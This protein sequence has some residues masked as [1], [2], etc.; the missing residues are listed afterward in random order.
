MTSQDGKSGDYSA[1]QRLDS[2]ICAV[3]GAGQG[4]GRE[5]AIALRSAGASVVCLDIDLA[6]ALSVAEEVGGSAFAMDA[7]KPEIVEAVV[8]DIVAGHG[9]LDAVIDIVGASFGAALL[10]IDEALIRRNF[11]LNLFQAMYVSRAAAAAMA[12]TGGGTLVFIGSAAG[13]TS[14]PNQII[15]GAAKAGLHHFVSCAASELGHLGIRVNAVAPGYVRTDRMIARFDDSQWSE[16]AAATPLQRCGEMADIAGAA[17]F[18]TQDL[19]GYISG[20]VLTVDGG[21]LNPPRVM[22]NSSMR[23][24]TGRMVND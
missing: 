8:A 18:L 13:L 24:I 4:I 2:R 16:I 6:S 3:V 11:D 23:Q 17:L 21:M 14:L 5:C 7:T 1:K 10:E 19:S 22:R 12:K 9:R 15:Y 20:Q